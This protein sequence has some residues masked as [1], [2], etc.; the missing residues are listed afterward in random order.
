MCITSPSFFLLRPVVQ[1]KMVKT[2]REGKNSKSGSTK[3]GALYQAHG[4]KNKFKGKPR[5]DYRVNGNA[6]LTVHGLA[7]PS[8]IT[9]LEDGHVTTG[10]I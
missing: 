3:F 10:F 9:D 2:H 6:N 7:P 4:G 5:F 1:E 8:P